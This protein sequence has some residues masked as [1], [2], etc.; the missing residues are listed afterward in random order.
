MRGGGDEIG[1]RDRAVMNTAGDQTR[2]V[3]HVDEQQ[4]AVFVSDLFEFGVVD[5]ARVST[6][7]GDDHFRFVL[8]G[9][10]GDLIEVDAV[11]VFGD[12]IVDEVIKLA[13]EV[14]SHAVCQVTAVG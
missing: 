14:Q 5:F 1:V 7:S 4:S 2:I 3:C 13:R 6:S 10:S 11:R 9:Q 8:F 12:A